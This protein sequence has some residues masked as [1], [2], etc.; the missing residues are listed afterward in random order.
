MRLSV[1]NKEAEFPFE[2]IWL[3]ADKQ[4]ITM[5]IGRNEG[6]IYGDNKIW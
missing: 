4:I 3:C 5:A 1:D 6:I 2:H